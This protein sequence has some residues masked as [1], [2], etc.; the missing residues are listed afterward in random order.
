MNFDLVG[1]AEQ[2]LAAMVAAAPSG[3]WPD[4]RYVWA[5]PVPFDCEQ[6]V[7]HG[8]TV[9]QGQPG[10]SAPVEK[11]RTYTVWGFQFGLTVCR[12]VPV[13]SQGDPLDAATSNNLG[14]SA[15]ADGGA[16]M[17]YAMQAYMAGTLLPPCDSVLLGPVT[18]VG[19]SGGM[20]GTTLLINAQIA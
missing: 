3:T 16:L 13:D 6:F 12:C 1:M 10:Q 15:L 9:I 7:A 4:R 17:R 11:V 18:W 20:L 8:V 5:G 2:A 14:A 19:P